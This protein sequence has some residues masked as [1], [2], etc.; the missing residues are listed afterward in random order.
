MNA[1]TLRRVLEGVLVAVG[2]AGCCMPFVEVRAGDR[3]HF[4]IVAAPPGLGAAKVDARGFFDAVTCQGACNDKNATV[5]YPATVRLPDVPP[6]PPRPPL[7]GPNDTLLVCG[8]YVASYCADR[9]MFGSGRLPRGT[10]RPPQRGATAA[11][12]LARSAYLEDASVHA[13]ERMRLELCAFGAPASLGRR[14]AAAARDERRHAT[15]VS[16]LASRFGAGAVR[17]RVR[18]PR[19]RGFSAFALDNAVEGCVRETFGALLA[20]HGSRAAGDRGVRVAMHSIAADELRHAA[21]AWA[22]WTWCAPRLAARDR[23]RIERAMTTAAASLTR[24][25]PEALPEIG[26]PGPSQAEALA[27]AFRSCL[28]LVRFG[29][30]RKAATPRSDG[31]SGAPWSRKSKAAHATSLRG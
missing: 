26:L 3:W 18:S 20:L 4:R 28:A 15:T 29:S 17:A 8:A 24:G 12:E 16:A 14:A 13:F 5:C 25:W 30:P 22:V 31:S 21:L 11:A 19:R 10:K 9:T 23:A 1:R 27:Q 2:S 6:S 7:V